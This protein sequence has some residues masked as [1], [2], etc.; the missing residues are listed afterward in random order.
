MH[1]NNIKQTTWGQLKMGNLEDL[2]SSIK[3]KGGRQITEMAAN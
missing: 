2:F 1:A 3:E